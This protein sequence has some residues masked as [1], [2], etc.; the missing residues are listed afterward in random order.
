MNGREFFLQFKGV[1]GQTDMA[2][3]VGRHQES[4]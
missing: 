3:Y 4:Y 2:E 1:A